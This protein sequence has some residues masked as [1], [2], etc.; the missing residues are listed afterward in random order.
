MWIG[1][2]FSPL[3]LFCGVEFLKL[4]ETFA[5]LTSVQGPAVVINVGI[6]LAFKIVFFMRNDCSRK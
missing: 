4:L 3:C 2:A 5:K 6:H 1:T